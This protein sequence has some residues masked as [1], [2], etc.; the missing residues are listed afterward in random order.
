[1]TDRA[2][3]RGVTLRTLA[4]DDRAR[5]LDLVAEAVGGAAYRESPMHFLRLALSGRSEDE[6]RGIVAVRGDRLVGC[7]L[8]GA[9]AGTVGTGRIHFVA[10]AP[11]AR[12]LGIGALMCEAAI[13][14]L[15]AAGARSVV[16]E[17][18]DDRALGDGHRL[19]ASCAFGEVAR[20]PDYYR[21]G[22]A[23]IV[24]HRGQKTS[25]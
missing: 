2:T 24:L 15:T 23:L 20:V 22:I 9:V 10:V 3:S 17:M 18:P 11:D 19:F 4:S 21:D 12:R 25:D 6:S 14:H 1:M 16:V 8:Y 5:L 7:V 13:S